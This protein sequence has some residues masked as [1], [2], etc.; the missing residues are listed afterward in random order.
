VT[1]EVDGETFTARARVTEGEERERLIALNPQF[2]D[3]QARTTRVIPVVV[4]E[5]VGIA[6]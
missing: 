6:T 5:R 4:L 2:N 1:V 3:V